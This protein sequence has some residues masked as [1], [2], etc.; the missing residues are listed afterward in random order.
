M[1]QPYIGALQNFIE[2][3]HLHIGFQINALF[4]GQG[5]VQRCRKAVDK[6]VFRFAGCPARFVAADLLLN[7]LIVFDGSIQSLV[8]QLQLPLLR[9]QLFMLLLQ[10]LFIHIRQQLILLGKLL[11]QLLQL[12]F[13]TC[14]L[15]P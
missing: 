12:S 15:L 6:A 14:Q 5:S 9:Q 7:P 4:A 1:Q 10:L 3:V 13:G 11:F 2:V 8:L